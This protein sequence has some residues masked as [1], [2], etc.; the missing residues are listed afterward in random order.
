MRGMNEDEMLKLSEESERKPEKEFKGESDM[1]QVP[2]ESQDFSRGILN[3]LEGIALGGRKSQEE[4]NAV[5]KVR[6]DQDLDKG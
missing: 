4:G 5:V 3:K 1:F 6:D 2:G